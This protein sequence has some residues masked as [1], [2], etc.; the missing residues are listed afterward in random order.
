MKNDDRMIGRLRERRQAIRWLGGTGALL[1]A[2]SGLAGGWQAGPVR[3][4]LLNSGLASEMV[5]GLTSESATLCVARPEQTEGPYFVDE[6]LQRSD[7]RSDPGSGKVSDGV[8]LQLR[9]VVAQFGASG[10]APLPQAQVDLWHCDAL[11]VYSD[12]Q[13]ASFDTTGQRFLRGYQ[14][15]DAQG[16]ARFTTIFPGWYPGRTVHVH[17]KVRTSA[18]SGRRYEFTSQWYF[19]DALIDRIHTMAPYAS[20]G[21]RRTRNR[22]DRIFRRGGEQLLLTPAAM[23]GGYAATFALGLQL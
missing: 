18:A 4:S 20:K 14:R 16:E 7:I 8:P 13:D 10:C 12:V 5:S 3:A 1:L 6:A 17:F 15:T 2:D 19:D 21:S 23:T 22:D 11:G 9:V